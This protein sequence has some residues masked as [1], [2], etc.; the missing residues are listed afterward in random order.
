MRL[1]GFDITRGQ[2]G[3]ICDCYFMVTTANQFTSEEHVARGYGKWIWLAVWRGYKAA[4]RS[5]VELRAKPGERAAK[6][7]S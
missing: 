7:W 6:G 2:L 5:S 1:R 3:W 4:K